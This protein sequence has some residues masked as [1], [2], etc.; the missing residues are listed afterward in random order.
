MTNTE[1]SYTVQV[2]SDKPGRAVA[3]TV[4]EG[5]SGP[6]I[7]LD[8]NPRNL[9]ALTDPWTGLSPR[10]ARSLVTALLLGLD[11]ISRAMSVC[12]DCRKAGAAAD[13]NDG[14]ILVDGSW[15]CEECTKIG[16]AAG[17]IGHLPIGER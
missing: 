6:G 13:V 7:V 14:T 2:G 10:E 8:I 12:V 4:T 9:P 1:F 17:T 16:L 11:A 15:V 3:V 5:E